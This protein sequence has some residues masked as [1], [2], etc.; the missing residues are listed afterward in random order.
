MASDVAPPAPTEPESPATAE[1]PLQARLHSFFG[2]YLLAYSERN[3]LS[4]SRFFTTDAVEN[5]KPFATMVQTYL[6]LFQS[7]DHASLHLQE[8][9]WQ[10]TEQG[11]QVDGRFTVNLHYRDGH[12]VSGSGPIAFRL[13]ERDASFLIETLN[14][15]FEQ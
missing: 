7:T 9:D 1:P 8:L 4:F 15:H 3:I 13:Q 5:N 11:V 14:Y 12:Q 2:A 10:E 6:D